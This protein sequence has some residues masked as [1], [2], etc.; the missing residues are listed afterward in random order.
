M[1]LLEAIYK[2][3]GFKIPC[4]CLTNV[5]IYVWTPELWNTFTNTIC[6]TF[7]HF[8]IVTILSCAELPGGRCHTYDG[9]WQSVL[10]RTD[11]LGEGGTV[12]VDGQIST[13]GKVWLVCDNICFK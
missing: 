12:V 2:K 10:D 9:Q 4:G 6:F 11:W 1:S 7:L 5:S 13:G 3:E 8:S